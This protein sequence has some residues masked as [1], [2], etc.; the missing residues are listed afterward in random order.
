MNPAHQPSVRPFLRGPGDLVLWESQP[1]CGGQAGIEAF[2]KLDARS[3]GWKA[4]ALD[5]GF[6]NS[7]RSHVFVL[8]P[9]PPLCMYTTP[10][11]GRV[12]WA[13]PLK[14]GPKYPR[15][16]RAQTWKTIAHPYSQ[17]PLEPPFLVYP[18]HVLALPKCRIIGTINEAYGGSHDINTFGLSNPIKPPSM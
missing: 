3:D 11:R 12:L 14:G 13:E 18:T 4:P 5:D 7:T 6:N 17:L 2:P 1:S 9:N 10:L 15:T 8:D 16:V